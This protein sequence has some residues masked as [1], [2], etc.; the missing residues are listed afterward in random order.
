L[1]RAALPS[2]PPDPWSSDLPTG[3]GPTQESNSGMCL[4]ALGGTGKLL[5]VLIIRLAHSPLKDIERFSVDDFAPA[6]AK[7][8]HISHR[9]KVV[10]T[11]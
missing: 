10:A 8:T 6:S 4:P 11:I 5:V 3:S 9:A 2:A 7:A 1:P